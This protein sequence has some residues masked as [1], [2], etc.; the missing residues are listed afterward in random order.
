MRLSLRKARKLEQKINSAAFMQQQERE[1]TIPTLLS[2]SAADI[3][4]MIADANKERAEAF[5]ANLS[6]VRIVHKIR[7]MISD[8]NHSSG[9][10]D[11][12]AEKAR[13]IAEK[14]L[15]ARL[16]NS[17]SS[18]TAEEILYKAKKLDEFSE[19]RYGG[20]FSKINIPS[21]T[22]EAKLEA[23]KDSIAEIEDRVEAIEDELMSLNTGL[24]IEIDESDVKLLKEAGILR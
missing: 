9:I 13:L 7:K 19:S 1:V 18:N 5:N 20:G 4:G 22:D 11:L 17:F 16:I 23:L 24:T 3:V 8:N 10:S 14:E 2:S 15:I 6:L 21:F 12:M